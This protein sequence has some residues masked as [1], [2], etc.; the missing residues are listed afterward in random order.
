VPRCRPRMAGVPVLGKRREHHA[1]PVTDPADSASV[2]AIGP[3][4]ATTALA[5][6]RCSRG[7]PRSNPAWDSRQTRPLATLE[8]T[9]TRSDRR[10]SRVLSRSPHLDG[11][12]RRRDHDAVTDWNWT[13]I[14]LPALNN[15]CSTGE[16]QPLPPELWP[17]WMQNAPGFVGAWFTPLDQPRS[18]SSGNLATGHAQAEVLAER[19][20]PRAPTRRYYRFFYCELTDGRVFQ[21][22]PSKDIGFGHH[23]DVRP[24]WLA[25]YRSTST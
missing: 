5:A 12:D 3:S 4:R 6:G 16:A 20:E 14:S 17:V 13:P 19:I 8:S 10:A 24:G 22:G 11:S 15:V 25:S 9:I 18:G 1:W 7:L 21:A 2:L 23:L